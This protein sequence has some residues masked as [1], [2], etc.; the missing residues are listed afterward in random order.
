[1]LVQKSCNTTNHYIVGGKGTM[2]SDGPQ[3]DFQLGWGGQGLR[4]GGTGS[5]DLRLAQ[6]TTEGKPTM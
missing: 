1:M 4:L 3:T 5:E 2:H 6:C